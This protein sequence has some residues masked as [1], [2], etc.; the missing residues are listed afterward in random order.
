MR[1]NVLTK[2]QINELFIYSEG[3][4]YWRKTPSNCVDI[5]DP[6]GSLKSDGTG[7]IRVTYKR[8]QY[9]LHNLI[10]VLHNGEIPDS[11]YVDHIDNDPSNNKIDNLQL[12][13]LP[14]NLRKRARVFS[15]RG[16]VYFRGERRNPWQ[17]K[18]NYKGRAIHIGSFITEQEAH[19]ALEAWKITNIQGS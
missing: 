11:L 8:K 17:A 6:A 14:E 15:P 12:L 19:E 4:L 1:T 3:N 13:T 5:K 7:Y 18:I 9:Q 2:A 10:W 16:C